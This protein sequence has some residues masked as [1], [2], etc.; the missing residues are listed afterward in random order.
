MIGVNLL[1]LQNVLSQKEKQLRHNLVF[2]V[3]ALGVLIIICQGLLFLANTLVEAR[4]TSAQK[5][6]KAL[7]ANLNAN[8]ETAMDLRIITAKISGI[9]QI[10]KNQTDFGKMTGD[11]L[12]LLLP[13]ASLKSFSQDTTG[14]VALT[15]VSPSISAFG[16]FMDRLTATS[17]TPLPFKEITISGIKEEGNSINFALTMKY[18]KK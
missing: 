13:N 8:Y 2:L 9:A 1:P 12:N 10:R 7:M 17:N 15:A 5:Q 18:E 14:N 3:S 6:Q 4:S 16:A 11:I